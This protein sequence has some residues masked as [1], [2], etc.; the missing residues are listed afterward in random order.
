MKPALRILIAAV[1]YLG[2]FVIGATSGLLGPAVYAYAGTF[3]PLLFGFIYLYCAANCRLLP[4]I[5]NL[6]ISDG[7][8]NIVL[9]T[10]AIRTLSSVKVLS[11]T[12]G[13]SYS[14]VQ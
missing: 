2:I 6:P 11:A 1:I 7:A 8:F 14:F 9:Q 3:L 12:K 5:P 4:R 13:K 10:A